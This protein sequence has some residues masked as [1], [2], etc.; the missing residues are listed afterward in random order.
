MKWL[1][2]GMS[3]M[4]VLQGAEGTRGARIEVSTA[5]T[6]EARSTGSLS[7]LKQPIG[8]IAAENSAYYDRTHIMTQEGK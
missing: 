4:L 1:Q 3:R 5:G 6:M 2:F 8:S 7:E